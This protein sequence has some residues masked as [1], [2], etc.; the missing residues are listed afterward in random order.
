MNHFEEA[1]EAGMK[2][3]DDCGMETSRAVY[4]AAL[5]AALPHL[6][7]MMAEELR[8]EGAKRK[9]RASG[10]SSEGGYWYDAADFVEGK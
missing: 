2:V 6:R 9:R 10:T 7:K 5:R 4:D 3:V 8:A 1:V